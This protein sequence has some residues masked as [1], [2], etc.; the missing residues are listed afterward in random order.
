M[1]LYLVQHA[2]AETADVDEER[3]L[4]A[5]GIRDVEMVGHFL[6]TMSTPV[7]RILHSG[8][9]RARET[10][11][12]LARYIG[13]EAVVEQVVGIRARDPAEPWKERLDAEEENLVMVAHMPFVARLASLLVRGEE[14][15][16]LF[17]F[18]PGTVLCLESFG[19]GRWSVVWMVPPA[20]VVR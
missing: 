15:P 20:L 6:E 10:A 16:E 5:G 3:H 14:D 19:E 13:P 7:S 12:R 17:R 18:T 4:T 1:R 11:E 2:E 9:V 8:K